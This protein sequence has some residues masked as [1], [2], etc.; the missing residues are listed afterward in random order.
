MAAIWIPAANSTKNLSIQYCFLVSEIVWVLCPGSMCF[1]IQI[2]VRGAPAHTY[3]FV[4]YVV[5]LALGL[6]ASVTIQAWFP[7]CR[8]QIVAAYIFI[9]VLYV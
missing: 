6:P 4:L 9:I 8:K 5:Y 7:N 2:S 3:I 1:N